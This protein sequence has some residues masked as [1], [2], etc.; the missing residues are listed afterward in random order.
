[1]F[2]VST[3][4][5]AVDF[6]IRRMPRVANE[7]ES[8]EQIH[9]YLRFKWKRFCFA[10]NGFVWCLLLA[11][12]TKA[13]LTIPATIPRRQRNRKCD[14]LLYTLHKTCTLSKLAY[15]STEHEYEKNMRAFRAAIRR[16]EKLYREKK[17]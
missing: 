5:N 17:V 14:R 1:M 7:K 4:R 16:N 15:V 9:H 6:C 12:G 11:F 13:S 8:V 3:R 10:A 2:A